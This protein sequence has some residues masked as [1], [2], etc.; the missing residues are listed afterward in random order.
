MNGR[1]GWPGCITGSLRP[2]WPVCHPTRCVC[3]HLP[4][5]ALF[6]LLTLHS[7]P[8]DDVKPFYADSGRLVSAASRRAEDL[9][10]PCSPTAE[11]ERASAAEAGK[12]LTATCWSGGAASYTFCRCSPVA[13]H[14]LSLV[15]ADGRRSHG[16]SCIRPP[17]ADAAAIPHRLIKERAVNWWGLFVYVFFIGAFCFYIWARAAHTLG[18]GPMLWW[19]GGWGAGAE[20]GATGR[21]EERRACPADL[22]T[23]AACLCLARQMPG[24][25]NPAGIQ[26]AHPAGTAPLCWLWRCWAGWPCCPT[27]SASPCAS[28]TTRSRRPMRRVRCGVWSVGVWVVCG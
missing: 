12:R 7:P 21:T 24:I 14:C 11:A 15:P 28:P 9:E 22:Y 26:T 1:I 19:V 18:L 20:V 2:C 10:D 13:S 25:W 16:A 4:T 5:L 23:C 6:P 17:Y 3:A 8:G 27:A